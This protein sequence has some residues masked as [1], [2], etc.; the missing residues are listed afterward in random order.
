[1]RIKNQSS[2]Q[3][4]DSIKKTNRKFL[5]TVII[6]LSVSISAI[7]LLD[8]YYKNSSQNNYDL[9]FQL[10]TENG[11]TMGFSD[12]YLEGEEVGFSDGY[13]EGYENGESEGYTDGFSDG[14]DVGYTRGLIA[15]AGTGYNIRDPTYQEMIDFI[16]S[17]KTDQNTY[18]NDYICFNFTAEVKNNAFFE[19]Y[20][21]GFV[22]VTFPN[23][24]HGMV[25]FDTIDQG[26]IF[27]EPQDDRIL[28]PVVGEPLFDRTFY[29]EI[30]WDDTVV[31][32]RIIW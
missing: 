24:N 3:I 15:G 10:G 17:D 2:Y 29:G 31:D 25:C 14:E 4:I 20:R 5:V 27:I 30:N 23:S 6:L 11:I 18:S 28:T 22:Y 8:Y 16:S 9:G 7:I 32:Y 13:L 21:C 19:G 12:G 1:M 26:L